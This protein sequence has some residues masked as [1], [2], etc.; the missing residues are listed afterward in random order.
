MKG[1]K[2]WIAALM[3]ALVILLVPSALAQVGVEAEMGYENAI[4]YLAAMPLRVRLTNDGA[5]AEL[6]VA[7]NLTRSQTEYDRYE[8]PVT[9]ASGAEMRL[10]LPVRVTYKQAEYTV[11][12]WQ[13]G[14]LIASRA[15]K[16][17]QVISPS[18]LLVGLLSDQPQSLRYLNINENND[19]L[20]RGEYWQTL[21]L[22]RD[23]FP[24]SLEMLRAFRILAVD[25]FDVTALSAAQQTALR[26]WLRE[27]GIVILGGGAGAS[28]SL[29]GF[30][31]LNGI[32][33]QSPWQEP[34]VD[35]ALRDALAGGQFGL[36]VQEQLSAPSLLATL[37]GGSGTVAE[38]SG[39]PLLDRCAVGKGV[40]YT[41]A[42]SLS[43]RPLSA[44]GGMTGLW[45]RLL[46]TYDQGL[47][48]RI[49]R[50]QQDYYSIYNSGDQYID[51]WLLRQMPL[52]NPD[53]VWAVAAIIAAAVLLS[54]LGSYFVLK[55]LDKREWMW[56]TV[57]ALSLGCAVIILALS[58]GMG[59]NKPALAAYSTVKVDAQGNASLTMRGGVASAAR[60]PMRVSALEDAE[61][62]VGNM[63]Y[64][65]FNDEDA[66]KAQ[67]RL[68]YTYT[69]G[70]I[71]T[72]TMP[73]SAPWDV[74]LVNVKPAEQPECPVSAS[75]WWEEDGLHGLVINGSSY[76]LAPGF[77]ATNLGY[78]SVPELL[79]GASA[80][81]AILENPNREKN[82]EG[83]NVYDGELVTAGTASLYDILQAAVYPPYGESYVNSEDPAVGLRRNLVET[84]HTDWGEYA[85]FHYVSFTDQVG[86]PALMV[87]GKRVDRVACETVVDTQM[88]YQPVGKDGLV[89]VTQGMIPA[90]NA[91]LDAAGAP[92][93]T[94]QQLENYS[95]FVLR[96]EPVVCFALGEIA[97][98]R[99]ED[100]T[101]EKISL[102]CESYGSQPKL[103]LYGPEG[104]TAVSY[105]GFPAAL[106]MKLVQ[107]CLDAEGR[108]FLRFSPGSGGA[109]NEI[110]NPAL[111]LEG[112]VK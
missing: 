12:V 19:Q 51:T 39:K 102:Q 26:Q 76:T 110:Y 88:T 32:T 60:E 40:V 91:E 74:R 13:E 15:V 95:Y 37:I 96:D 52:S 43:E 33:A 46:L 64:Y 16:P 79:P 24:D 55:R 72:L 53:P 111:T 10:T 31:A 87:D 86:V 56:I 65:Y 104:W 7:V 105:S 73:A 100:L 11:E 28:A 27:G 103:W 93:S 36:N 82:S 14:Q 66:E 49:A 42:F 90:Y 57:P 44:W 112:R 3:A 109:N 94:G 2:L 92:R 80:Q 89:R 68:R 78:C 83:P 41:A 61:L 71:M 107:S 6:T 75:I 97:G 17:Q 69:Y 63:D 58:R 18:T 21:A 8:Y 84:C 20:M 54:G 98:V 45:Q 34:R 77:V 35:A 1:R 59:L 38:I 4:T 101:L 25:G 30:G 29:R 47:Y 106:D 48:T 62:S 50:E 85:V 70:D 108:L 9:L 5:D 99:L 22:D 67:P 23:S 81:V